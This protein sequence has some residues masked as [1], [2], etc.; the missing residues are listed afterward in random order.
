MRDIDVGQ[1][2]QLAET[3]AAEFAAAAIDP[4]TDLT[5]GERR[6]LVAL[7]LAVEAG[8]ARTVG[9]VPRSAEAEA[10]LTRAILATAGEKSR[11]NREGHER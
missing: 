7:S 3:I 10:L 5:M 6:A 9:L 11:Q 2:L 1:V 8:A 4:A